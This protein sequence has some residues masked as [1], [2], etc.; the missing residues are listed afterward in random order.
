MSEVTFNDIATH[1]FYLVYMY[2]VLLCLF[3]DGQCAFPEVLVGNWI[4]SEKGT[5]AFTS[6]TISDYPMPVS[7]T[8]TSINLKCVENSGD[9][10]LVQ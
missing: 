4:S 10:Y 6:D 1:T 9:K 3:L 8:V 5:L 7:V 2:C